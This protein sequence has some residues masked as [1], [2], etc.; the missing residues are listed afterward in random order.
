MVIRSLAALKKSSKKKEM[1]A[2]KKEIVEVLQQVTGR[3]NKAGELKIGMMKF[4]TLTLYIL[5]RITLTLISAWAII[6]CF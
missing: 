2:E 4:L 5:A 1:E 6:S 3:R